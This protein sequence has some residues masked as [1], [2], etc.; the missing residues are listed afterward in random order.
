MGATQLPASIDRNWVELA[1]STPTGVTSV[2]FTSLSAYNYYRVTYSGDL[3]NATDLNMRLNNSSVNYIS[4]F[5]YDAGSRLTI[6]SSESRFILT[7]GASGQRNKIMVTLDNTSGLTTA[8]GYSCNS[9]TIGNSF[10]GAWLTKEQIN[11][12]DL[13]TGTGPNFTTGT[14]KIYGSN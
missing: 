1:S 3:D 9:T 5:I 12:I 7:T 13:F 10:E 8:T 14:I 6:S 2:S 11:R 4:S